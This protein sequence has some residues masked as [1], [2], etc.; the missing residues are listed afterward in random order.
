M[1]PPTFNDAIR[2]TT[3]LGIIQA[4]RL[5]L[6]N[7]EKKL[8]QRQQD[9]ATL[10]KARTSLSEQNI[11]HALTLYGVPRA[12]HATRVLDP[13]RQISEATI[14][15][16]TARASPDPFQDDDLAYLPLA[17]LLPPTTTTR[18]DQP[19]EP[20]WLSPNTTS[21]NRGGEYPPPPDLTQLYAP[22]PRPVLHD[23][24]LPN[25]GSVSAGQPSASSS[26]LASRPRWHAHRR[27]ARRAYPGAAA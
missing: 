15:D 9:H 13:N 14:D 3:K 7:E 17:D 21:I 27:D 23:T 5:R 11:Q 8:P 18:R 10:T 22:T 2:Q 1:T 16:Q 4:V 20:A 19:R 24:N 12:H 6:T 26:R 25:L